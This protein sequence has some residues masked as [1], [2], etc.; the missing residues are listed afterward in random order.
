MSKP[1]LN[2]PTSGYAIIV[3]GL[4][5]TEFATT[6]GVEIG[7]KDLKRRFPILQVEIFDAAVQ[8]ARDVNA[9]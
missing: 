3:D 1:G 6:D 2:L 4:V 8:A 7:A 9:P 5:K